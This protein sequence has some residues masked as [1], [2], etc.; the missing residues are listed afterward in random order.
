M[1]VGMATEEEGITEVAVLMLV[2][3]SK[4][5]SVFITC[6]FNPINQHLQSLRMSWT[7]HMMICEIELPDH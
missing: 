6:T 7:F 5:V 3:L 1:T 2:R 4:V